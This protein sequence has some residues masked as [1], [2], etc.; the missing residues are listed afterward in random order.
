MATITAANSIFFLSIQDLYPAP[1][2]LQGYSAD[3]AF[4]TEATDMAEVV[5]G[6]DGHMSTGFVFNPTAQTVVIM[7]DSPSL[8]LFEQLQSATKT[9]REVYRL[10]ATIRLP[11][12][13]KKYTLSNGVLQQAP[14]IAAVK[15]TLQ[16]LTFRLM[17]ESVIAEPF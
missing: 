17:W 9:S 3:D 2:L 5:M 14:A 8:D 10:D 4:T 6:V 7:P 11:A 16:P 1:Q 12:V 15:K 13:G